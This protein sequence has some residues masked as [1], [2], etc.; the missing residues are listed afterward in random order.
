VKRE[1]NLKP[2]SLASSKSKSIS[3]F[4]TDWDWE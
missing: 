1:D 4:S 2:L 3:L